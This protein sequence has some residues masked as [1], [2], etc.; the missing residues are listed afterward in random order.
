MRVIVNELQ[1]LKQRTGIGHYT[2]E[3]LHWLPSLAGSECIEGFPTG[4]VRR[5]TRLCFRAGG[6]VAQASAART[7]R[8]KL[9]G[10]ARD[11]WQDFLNR[12]FRQVCA[13]GRFDLY[14]EPNYLPMP[15]DCPTIATL[16]DLSVVLHPQWHP[17]DRVKR[18]EQ[19]M[20]E[21]LSRCVHFLADTDAVRREVIQHLGVAPQRVTR[22]HMGIRPDLRPLPPEIVQR[23]LARLG[24]PPRYLLCLGTIEPRKNVLRLL[25]VY[26]SLP[27]SIREKWPLL[28]VGGWGWNA[29][30]TA[31]YLHDAAKPRG[32]L[33]LGYAADESLPALYNGARAL[34]FP[35][36]Y[37]GFG[38]PPLEMLACGGAVLASTAA[39]LQETVAG[40]A[41]MMPPDDDDAWR[42]AL[43][44]VTTD[45]DWHRQLC[46]GATA[47][48]QP[49]TWQR[50]AAET[51]QVYRQLCEPTV[52]PQRR[53]G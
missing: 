15:A 40:Q 36:Y 20:P 27:A 8:S 16:H 13:A 51:F 41:H 23:A 19:Q 22:V 46:R 39:A 45:D 10:C 28:L 30:E 49:Y 21:V 29:E 4:W 26:V 33:H 18:F 37:E 7:W 43:L 42:A 47:V 1:S 53:A 31:H 14:H 17:A 48:A 3:L 50:T 2:A 9:T 34:V 25:K 35:S 12:R 24:L 52:V 32:V 38:L 44:R 6:K 5:A 11:R